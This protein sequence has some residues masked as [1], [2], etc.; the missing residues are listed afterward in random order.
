MPLE[1]KTI[2]DILRPALCVTVAPDDTVAHA[3]GL[4]SEEHVSSVLV[5]QDE[6]LVGIFTERDF[7]SRVAV[8]GA[9]ANRVLVRD[10]MTPDPEAL[11]TTDSVGAAIDLMAGQRYRNVPIVSD[12]RVPLGVLRVREV[13][14]HLAV[15]LNGVKSSEESVFD[16]ASKAALKELGHTPVDRLATADF[17]R[18]T[19]TSPIRDALE[20]MR[21]RKVGAIVVQNAYDDICGIFT[22]RD[23]VVRVARDDTNLEA[24]V[25]TVMTPDP[26]R[27]MTSFTVSAALSCMHAG[28][29]RHLPI[30]DD[31]GR[32]NGMISI[33][34]I[35]NLVA[36]R[37]DEVEL[38]AT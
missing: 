14:A 5:T 38:A 22:E 34:D 25:L 35:L 18:V 3:I 31:T 6:I 27:L 17:V 29:F 4:M 9:S 21:D 13:I 33:R 36:S 1:S 11:L 26:I 23:V 2:Q 12:K 7:V 8:T 37:Y 24:P 15:Q 28:R 10:V 30:A 32:A 19:Q 20:L 16:A